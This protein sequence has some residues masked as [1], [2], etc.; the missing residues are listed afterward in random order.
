MAFEE[1]KALLTCQACG[2]VHRVRWFRTPTR[3][4]IKLICLGCSGVLYQGATV[5]LYDEDSLR[6]VGSAER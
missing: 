4:P 5:H 1:G 6:R 2:A 3:E